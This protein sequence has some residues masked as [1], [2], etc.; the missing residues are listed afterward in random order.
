MNTMVQVRNG[1][2][3]VDPSSGQLQT[4]QTYHEFSDGY[5]QINIMASNSPGLQL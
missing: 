1:L 2:F 3:L 5:F 4:N